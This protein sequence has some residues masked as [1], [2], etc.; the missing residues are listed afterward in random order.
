[1]AESPINTKSK[2]K[3][4]AR[5]LPSIE[6]KE[7]L[8]VPRELAAAR[9]VPRHEA[10]VRL[11]L[12]PLASG[13]GDIRDWGA[14]REAEVGCSRGSSV[15]HRLGED[16]RPAGRAAYP[17]RA[18]VEVDRSA[19]AEA[20]NS[21]GSLSEIESRNVGGAKRPAASPHSAVITK[22]PR[23]E[24]GLNALWTTL[25]VP[26]SGSSSATC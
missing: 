22:K 17:I 15:P 10:L 20:E 7:D 1:M 11:T 24:A 26:C 3:A 14:E 4:R 6:H 13:H 16:T 2:G 25:E 19:E 18:G 23:V 12:E 8:P 9:E 5:R 21:P